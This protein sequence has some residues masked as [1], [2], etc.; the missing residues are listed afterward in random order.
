MGG[1]AQPPELGS[2]FAGSS[3]VL[4]ELGDAKE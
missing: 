3:L 4:F 2:S 1:G